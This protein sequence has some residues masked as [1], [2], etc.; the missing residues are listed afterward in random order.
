MLNRICL[1]T[2]LSFAA[3]GQTGNGLIKGVVS[4]AS[5]AMVSAAKITL[6][7]SETNVRRAAVSSSVVI[8]YF[9]EV[10]PGP[11]VLSVESAGFKKWVGTLQSQVGQTSQVNVTLNVGTL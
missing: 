3:L 9:G 1:F 5:G 10:P 4:D 11:Y 7:N 6:V 8:Y 2:L